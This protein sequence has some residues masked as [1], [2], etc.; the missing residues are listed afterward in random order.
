[1]FDNYSE[2]IAPYS[3]WQ[4][5]MG[6]NYIFNSSLSDL[7]FK[8]M[9]DSVPLEKRLEAI[10]SMK[11][12]YTDCFANRCPPALGHYSEV[13]GQLG[14]FCYMIW[15][16]SPL[17]H[18]TNKQEKTEYYAVLFEVLEA[19]LNATNISCIESALHGLGEIAPY[20]KPAVDVIEKAMP[21]IRRKGGPRLAAYAEAAKVGAIQ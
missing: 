10:R 15:D 5:A 16:V 13:K 2:D 19:G 8:L 11:I 18:C 17:T 6:L 14:K 4:I 21:W 3:D 7:A 1:M 20:Y 12:L 9:D